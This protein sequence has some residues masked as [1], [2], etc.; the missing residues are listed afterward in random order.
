MEYQ[1]WMCVVCGF[2][3]DESEGLP[4]E[5]IPPGTRWEELPVD[6]S[7]GEC[8]AGKDNFIRLGS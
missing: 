3:Y 6:W 1:A 8:G 4:E 5:G 2:V 7:C